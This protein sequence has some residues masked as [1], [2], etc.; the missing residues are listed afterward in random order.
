MLLLLG[1]LINTA[2][3]EERMRELSDADVDGFLNPAEGGNDCD[4]HDA[5]VYP[6]AA[7]IPYDGI[8]QDCSGADLD[9]VDLDGFSHDEDCDDSDDDAYPGASDACYDGL[10]SDCAGDD[11][12]D[13]DQDG[14]R[15][16][17][18]TGGTDCDDGDATVYPDATDTCYDG[19][20]ADC[21]GD[22]DFDCD[23]DG[24]TEDDGD[25]DDAD[26]ERYPGADEGWSDLGT[27]ND[28]GG[29]IDDPVVASLA[30]AEVIIDPPEGYGYFGSRLGTV[31]DVD[32]DGLDEIF[33]SAP[34]ASP[35]VPYQGAAFLVAGAQLSG[36]VQ[37]DATADQLLAPDT[38]AFLTAHGT[39]GLDGLAAE[40]LVVNSGAAA[41][42]AGNTWAVATDDLLG[43]GV[44]SPAEIALASFQGSDGDYSGTA[45]VAGRDID[46]DGLHDLLLDAVGT[47]RAFGFA[48]PGSGSHH[49][50]DADWVWTPSLSGGSLTLRVPGD[51][52]GDGVD[53]LGVSQGPDA[54]ETVGAALYRGG[55]VRD[56]PF[57]EEADLWLLGTPTLQAVAEL[58]EGR[59]LF[60]LEY[61]GAVL[62][63]PPAGATLD[64]DADADFHL[65][66]L[67][68][69]GSFAGAHWAEWFG[70]AG[71]TLL[72]GAPASPDAVESGEVLAWQKDEISVHAYASNCACAPSATN[73]A[74]APARRWRW[75]P[76]SPATGTP[77]WP[78]APRWRTAASPT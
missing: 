37:L 51:V 23:S 41:D 4:D 10:D 42:G 38:Y 61:G 22:D 14:A 2:L 11:D 13:C 53:D 70:D 30:D 76:I 39:T 6:G 34:Y 21:A 15:I 17:T 26:A 40:F 44:Q 68:G 16:D 64:P 49:A 31:K 66:R 19:V 35:D 33:I 55:V 71:D 63:D 29:A 77:T 3:Y 48:S 78:W 43:G 57:G 72:I 18:A 36:H 58:D 67:P 65:Y 46:G 52:D 50:D 12:F 56:G 1:C 59:A 32:G 20:D 47:G 8:D 54:G 25:C 74:T 60:T 5:S 69:E 73:R 45:P 9:D 27:D 75:C 62:V 24:F 28:C 7:E